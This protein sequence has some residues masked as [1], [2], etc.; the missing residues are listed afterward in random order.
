MAL[1]MEAVTIASG[2]ALVP[3]YVHKM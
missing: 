1:I 2:T 3:C